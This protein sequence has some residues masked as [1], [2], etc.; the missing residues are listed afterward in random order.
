MILDLAGKFVKFVET[1]KYSL[2]ENK[3]SPLGEDDAEWRLTLCS[4]F[5]VAPKNTVISVHPSRSLQEGDA[6]TMT[7]SSEGLPAPEIFWSKKLDNGN[8]QLLS[9]NATL[10]LVAMRTEDSGNYVC[11]GV[12]L[13][14]RNKAEVELTVQGE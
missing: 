2:Q 12:N 8:L 14:G 3:S 11:E 5:S 7:C 6:V 13:V 1:H 9:G 10:T 4:T